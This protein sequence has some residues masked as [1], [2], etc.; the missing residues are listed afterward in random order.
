MSDNINESTL[1]HGVQR[2]QLADLTMA[3]GVP[4]FAVHVSDES[5]HT[6]SWII[7]GELDGEHLRLQPQVWVPDAIQA[8]VSDSDGQVWAITSEDELVTNTDLGQVPGW[9]QVAPHP[10]LNARDGWYSRT[11]GYLAPDGQKVELVECLCWAS[12][13]LLIGTFSRRLYRWT[14][15]DGARLEYDDHV[16]GTLG[17]VNNIVQTQDAIYALGYAGLILR[18]SVDGTWLRMDGPWATEAGAFIN[19]IAGL[20]GPRGELWA[21]AA[22]GSV[23]SVAGDVTRTIAQVPGEPLGITRFQ[24]Q[25]FVSTLDGC[26]E[27]LGDGDTVLIKRD[28]LMGKSIDAGNCLIAVD[29]E[30]QHADHAQ[31][32][33]WLRTRNRD[34]WLRP[35]I[36]RA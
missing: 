22:G 13:G 20:E 9:R 3:A 15:G 2:Y 23:V 35:V 26:Y 14:S 21:I 11:L 33:L 34:A 27:L 28:I 16:V 7:R 6:S 18:R 17:G 4:W 10:Q 29:A 36:C 12:D 24:C 32:H 19:M 30:P 8:I 1:A 31:V 25:W 5:G